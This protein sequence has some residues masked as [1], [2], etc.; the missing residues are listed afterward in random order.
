[1]NINLL[2]AMHAGCEDLDSGVLSENSIYA[3]ALMG[4]EGFMDTIKEG[5]KAS[6]AWIKQLLNTILDAIL[7]WFGGRSRVV[8][9]LDNLKRSKLFE[10]F[11]PKIAVLVDKY[12]I[13]GAAIA[14]NYLE[15][16][17]DQEYQSFFRQE[18]PESAEVTRFF[19]S[20]NDM[21]TMLS[22]YIR[23]A[24]IHPTEKHLDF[25]DVLG[26]AKNAMEAGRKIVSK[27][28]MERHPDNKLI[29]NLN[30]VITKIGKAVNALNNASESIAR[31]I[32][33]EDK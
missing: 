25:S 15:S 33:K 28:E 24:R 3:S 32:E 9:A 12:A 2:D 26:K 8:K 10:I 1:M 7:F 27:I 17:L 22:K 13:P 16:A 23:D 31:N 11:K 30:S 6:I 18:L 21:S 19:V 29:Y 5:A 4:G 14:H 20:I